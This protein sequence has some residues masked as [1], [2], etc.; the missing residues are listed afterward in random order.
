MGPRLAAAALIFAA[1][2]YT[3]VVLFAIL[4]IVGYA[5]GEALVRRPLELTIVL[6]LAGSPVLVWRWCLARA[7][8][9]GR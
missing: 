1:F 6:L 9:I 8:T 4:V 2:A 5:G 3:L 7:R